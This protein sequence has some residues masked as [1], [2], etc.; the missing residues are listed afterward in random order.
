M[1]A[2]SSPLLPQR[3]AAGGDFLRRREGHRAFGPQPAKR[4][5]AGGK[6]RPAHRASAYPSFFSRY[7]R[8]GIP[9][10]STDFD[11]K[12][13]N[14]R[15]PYPI[16]YRLALQ[17]AGHGMRAPGSEPFFILPPPVPAA[18]GAIRVRTHPEGFS[19]KRGFVTSGGKTGVPEIRSDTAHAPTE[20]TT[21]PAA[22]RKKGFRHDRRLP[23]PNVAP[24]TQ[25][26]TYAP[27]K[28]H[29]AEPRSRAEGRERARILRTGHRTGRRTR[30]AGRIE[31]DRPFR[32]QNARIA[33][34]L[35]TF[36]FLGLSKHPHSST[37]E[38]KR[39][40]CAY[41]LTLSVL[42]M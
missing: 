20:A 26:R 23:G 7:R 10:K 5:A 15:Q 2:R 35:C 6:R 4:V 39:Q 16:P 21:R 30:R 41:P 17:Q 1:A 19:R 32:F 9:D 12:E 13:C 22:L 42:V 37:T 38:E 36:S 25:L 27:A 40:T 24:E 18:G 14:F 29:S 11:P 34:I 8:T 28:L 33:R 31:T 3:I